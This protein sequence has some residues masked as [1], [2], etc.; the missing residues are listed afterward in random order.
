MTE[1][2]KPEMGEQQGDSKPTDQHAETVA[3]DTVSISKAEFEKIQRA[4]KEA[5]AEA[6]KHRKRVEAIEQAEQ[7]KRDAE[8]SEMEK[9]QKKL[10]ALEQERQDYAAKLAARELLDRKREIARKHNLPDALATRLIGETDEDIE[11][12]AKALLE[13]L[14]KPPPPPPQKVPQPGPV[15]PTNPGGATTGETEAQV[16]ARIFGSPDD[17]FSLETTK[18]LGGGGFVIGE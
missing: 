18:K 12:D 4:L 14:P 15:S 11:A 3:V 13:T 7:A 2:S 1:E 17:L 9:L 5:N 8:L 16:R 6:A 10:T